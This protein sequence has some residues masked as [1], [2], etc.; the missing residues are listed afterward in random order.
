MTIIIQISIE[1]GTK[2]HNQTIPYLKKVYKIALFDF[3]EMI[4]KAYRCVKGTRFTCILDIRSAMFFF[5]FCKNGV[6]GKNWIKKSL[7]SYVNKC[8]NVVENITF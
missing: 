5:S 1:A 6:N 3:P 4:R 8:M 7:H 2:C